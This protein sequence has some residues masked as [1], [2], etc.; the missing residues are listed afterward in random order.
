MV[1][2]GVYGPHSGWQLAKFQSCSLGQLNV[3]IQKYINPRARFLIKYHHV[4]LC[5]YQRLQNNDLL[6][7]GEHVTDLITRIIETADEK[8]LLNISEC[9]MIKP[10][11]VHYDMNE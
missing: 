11:N 9:I 3:L 8:N 4:K 7:F 2:H 1:L 6:I 10:M 5:C